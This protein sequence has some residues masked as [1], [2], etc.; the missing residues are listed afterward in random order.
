VPLPVS[1][2]TVLKAHKLAQIQER[3][4]R[5]ERWQDNDLVFRTTIGTPL[6]PR[7]VA[8]AF[9]ALCKK[10]GIGKHNLHQLRHT[11]A[12]LLAAQGVHPRVAMQVLGHSQM[13]LTM[14][15]YT[16]VA[17]ELGR[18][19]VDLIDAALKG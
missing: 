1:C 6:D 3:P 9:D 13:S 5:R 17:D 7:T 4:V 15:V 19:A 11:A 10:A 8:R 16:D 18:D 2:V 12:S 14:N